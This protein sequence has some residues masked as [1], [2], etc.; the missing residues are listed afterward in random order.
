MSLEQL[1]DESVERY[2]E[3]IRKQANADRAPEPS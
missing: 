2:Y 1:S 3:S